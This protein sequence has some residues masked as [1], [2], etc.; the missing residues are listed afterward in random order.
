MKIY[1]GIPMFRD[2][3][4]AWPSGPV[5]PKVYYKY[6]QYQDG[7]MYHIPIYD[8]ITVNKIEEMKAIIDRVLEEVKQLDITEMEAI[9]RVDNGPWAQVFDVNDK[10]HEQIISKESMYNYYK[11]YKKKIRKR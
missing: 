10:N 8:R 2:V 4:Y 3:F 5:I 7:K 11:Q 9:C 1:N 6:F